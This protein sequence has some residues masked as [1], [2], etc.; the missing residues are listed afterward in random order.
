MQL[1]KM[2]PG[3]TQL[4]ILLV[5]IIAVYYFYP[6]Y[7][8]IVAPLF[9]AITLYF[10]SDEMILSMFSIIPA[11]TTSITDFII[12]YKL[13]IIIALATISAYYTSL[14]LREK[15]HNSE[16]S[17]TINSSELNLDTTSS[18]KSSSTEYL[19]PTPNPSSL[20]ALDTDD[21]DRMD[22]LMSLPKS[23]KLRSRP[24]KLSRRSG[25]D[26]TD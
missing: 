22:G 2:N 18:S 10:A 17:D 25:L 24:S 12:K 16:S 3:Q 23:S 13:Y 14:L 15:K 26:L 19:P 4:L 5:S 7:I 11:S 20:D 9:V 1:L 21:L 8:G 6:E